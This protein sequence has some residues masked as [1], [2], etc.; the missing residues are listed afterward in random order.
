MFLAEPPQTPWDLN[1]QLFGIRV[2]ISPFFWL[3]TALLG[4]SFAQVVATDR[5]AN[6]NVGLGLIMWTAIVL[7][8]ITVHEFGHVLAFRYYGIDA[9]VVLYQFGGLAVPRGSFGF[10]RQVR[11][12]SKEQ[13]VISGAGPAASL[14]LGI[15]VAA[16]VHIG[17]FAMAN[18]LPFIKQLDFLE[19]GRVPS[20]V[21]WYVLNAVLFVNIWWA[22]MNLLPVYPL[23]GGQIS[24]ELFVLSNYQTGIRY[25]LILSIVVAAAVALWAFSKQ[26]TYL[27]LMFGMLGFS[28][29]QI[30][31]QYSGRGGYGG[32]W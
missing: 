24:R 14:L 29:Y 7:V 20:A 26:D 4:W 28:S 2:R 3:G 12:E 32:G 22:L 15:C 25:S 27:G 8:S 6:L 30:L 13:I 23:D 19:E 1:L 9:D 16:I 5:E 10:G 11:L 31:Q 18:P 21:L 17:G